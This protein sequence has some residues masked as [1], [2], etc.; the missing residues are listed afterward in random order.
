MRRVV[1]SLVCMAGVLAPGSRAKADPSPAYPWPKYSV[2]PILFSPTD[3][4]VNGAEVQE[5]AAAIRSAMAAIQGFYGDAL[6]G[7]TFRL[8]DLQVVQGNQAKEGY[9]IEWNGGNIYTDGVDIVGNVEAAVVEELHAR[10]YPTPPGQNEDGYTVLIFVKGAGG[11]AGGRVFGGADGGWGILG[12]WAIDSLQGDVQEGEYWWSGRR[13][14]IGAA[15]HEL[16]HAFGLPHPDAYGGTWGTT[17]MGEWWNY[18]DLG[19]NDWEVD[20]LL[21]NKSAFFAVPEPTSFLM[22]GAGALAVIVPAW[23]RSRRRPG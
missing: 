15:A 14:Q 12:D 17:V 1:L 21:A 11:W 5:E 20:H 10:G 19:L 9:G 13:L 23:S 7:R 22:L 2:L 18:P 16:G 8:N 6:G 4:D 3:W